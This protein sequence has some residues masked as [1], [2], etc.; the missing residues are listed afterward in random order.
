M[1]VARVSRTVTEGLVGSRQKVLDMLLG[2]V[3]SVLCLSARSYRASRK[4]KVR[5]NIK[6]TKASSKTSKS[7]AK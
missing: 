1:G 6:T 7:H 2:A 4:K 5:I 3:V